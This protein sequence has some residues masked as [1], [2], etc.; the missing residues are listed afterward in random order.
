M[1]G[2]TSGTGTATGTSGAQAQLT[3]L[4]DTVF[5]RAPDAEG[6][7]FWTAA[8]NGGTSLDAVSDALVASREFQTRH[9]TLS[10]TEFVRLLYRNGLEREAEPEGLNFWVSGLQRRVTDRG[11][12][13]LDIADSP[14]GVASALTSGV[15]TQGTG[16]GTQTGTGTTGTGT[17]TATDT[18]AAATDTQTGTDTTGTTGTGTD[19]TGTGTGTQTGT[20]TS[21]TTDQQGTDQQ[22]GGGQDTQPSGKQTAVGTTDTGQQTSSTGTGLGDDSAFTFVEFRTPGGEVLTVQVVGNTLPVGSEVVNAFGTDT[23][24]DPN[25]DAVLVFGEPQQAAQGTTPPDDLLIA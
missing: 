7:A 5:D 25:P 2:A 8:L 6:L 18:T 24:A 15:G 21:G 10:D 12:E 23:D 20:Q 13:A 22:D 9:G 17:G 3:R 19:A 16:T 1:S 14:E 11:D 4:Y